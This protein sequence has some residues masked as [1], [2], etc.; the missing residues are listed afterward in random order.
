MPHALLHGRAECVAPGR[1]HRAL[2]PQV[3][4]GV[5]RVWVAR[6]GGPGES[7][8]PSPWRV[9]A[10]PACAG[11]GPRGVP[12]AVCPPTVCRRRPSQAS[13]AHRALPAGAGG[14]RERPAGVPPAS[15]GGAVARDPVRRS[16]ACV[17]HGRRGREHR[18]AGLTPARLRK[19]ASHGP[20]GRGPQRGQPHPARRVSCVRGGRGGVPQGCPAGGGAR[21]PAG[22]GQARSR[23]RS[24]AEQRRAGD[25]EQPPLVPRCGCPPRLTPGVR[26]QWEEGQH[27]ADVRRRPCGVAPSGAS[28]CSY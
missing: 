4:S 14:S 2:V 16:P 25:G 11:A 9:P 22:T 26:L 20:R 24:G 15:A 27:K 18:A 10:R 1:K 7:V 12:E 3:L 21:R 8:P 5:V 6:G 28:S 23:G 17:S 13:G 19:R